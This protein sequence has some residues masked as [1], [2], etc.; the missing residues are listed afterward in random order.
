MPPSRT[1]SP[2]PGLPPSGSVACSPVFLSALAT[3]GLRGSVGARAPLCVQHP[4]HPC[5]P[6]PLR[7]RAPTQGYEMTWRLPRGGMVHAFSRRGRGNQPPG[8]CAVCEPLSRVRGLVATSPA[9]SA[10]GSFVVWWLTRP[11]SPLCCLR[12]RAGVRF[13]SF[14]FF[15]FLFL[16]HVDHPV[17]PASVEEAAFPHCVFLAPCQKAGDLIRVDLFAGSLFRSVAPHVSLYAR[18]VLF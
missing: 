14:S 8:R 12:Q 17:F 4:A 2:G 6:A 11:P 18:T 13:L 5:H 10:R 1:R 16:L 7:D 9:S 15:S 3:T